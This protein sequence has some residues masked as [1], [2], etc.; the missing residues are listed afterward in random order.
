MI[1]VTRPRC[2]I[3]IFFTLNCDTFSN[4]EKAAVVIPVRRTEVTCSEAMLTLSF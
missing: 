2:R 4:D 3:K 1:K